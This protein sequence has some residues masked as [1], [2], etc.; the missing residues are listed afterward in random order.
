MY[1]TQNV[2][3]HKMFPPQ[4]VSAT[5]CI[6]HKMYPD[7]A[8]TYK[9]VNVVLKAPKILFHIKSGIQKDGIRNLGLT[10]TFLSK[11]RRRQ[12]SWEPGRPEL[13]SLLRGA[14]APS[15]ARVWPAPLPSPAQAGSPEHIQYIVN[16]E[17]I[18]ETVSVRDLY[19]RIFTSSY[20]MNN[21]V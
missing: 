5:K 20:T 21:R 8:F 4:N 10:L 1:P 16:S 13:S 17:P 7:I 12:T 18:Q 3:S 19:C 9:S 15:W 6:R 11:L 2:S 14:P